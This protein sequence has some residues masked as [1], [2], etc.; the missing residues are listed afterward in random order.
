MN[1]LS[2]ALN[3]RDRI[4]QGRESTPCLV[5]VDSQSVKLSP[6]PSLQRGLDAAKKVNGRK[7][8]IIVDTR[9]RLW[10][11]YVHSANQA[12]SRRVSTY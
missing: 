1:R 9:G 12:G 7:R 5:C 11:V 2:E 8:Q 6:L 3:Q 10:S 4:T